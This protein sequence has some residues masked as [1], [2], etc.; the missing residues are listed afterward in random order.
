[1]FDQYLFDWL[2]YSNFQ[3]KFYQTSIKTYKKDDKMLKGTCKMKIFRKDW[4]LTKF[5]LGICIQ[6]KNVP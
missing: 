4:I 1:M 6:I 2:I 3:Q 5:L